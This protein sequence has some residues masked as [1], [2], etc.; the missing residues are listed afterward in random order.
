M[1]HLKNMHLNLDVL[2]IHTYM[3]YVVNADLMRKI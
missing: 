3:T 2:W 1:Q